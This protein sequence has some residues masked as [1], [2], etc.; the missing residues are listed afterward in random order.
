[1]SE[2]KS[3][4][5]RELQISC[6]SS[7]PRP[8][9]IPQANEEDEVLWQILAHG[10]EAVYSLRAHTHRCSFCCFERIYR[11]VYK[12]VRRGQGQ[13]LYDKIM[14]WQ[15]NWLTANV[16]EDLRSCISSAL[17]ALLSP[18][19]TAGSSVEKKYEENRFLGLLKDSW[20]YYCFCISH[21]SNVV[22]YLVSTL[23]RFLPDRSFEGIGLYECY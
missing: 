18:N 1:M 13:W 23:S 11:S 16:L 15:R 6:I 4:W 3:I 8:K 22:K 21:D 2:V 9:G 5:E 14:T 17:L 12:A 10:L 20:E 19:A 7:R